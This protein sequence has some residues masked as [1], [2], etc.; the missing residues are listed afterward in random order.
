MTEFLGN[1]KGSNGTYHKISKG[2]D[3]VV[4]CDCWAW[5]KNKT[6]KHLDE[7]YH[8]TPK[9]RKQLRQVVMMFKI[10][11]RVIYKARGWTGTLTDVSEVP[12]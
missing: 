2:S 4:Y 10:G 1:I 5:K 3:G 8:Q 9:K 12:I 6:C 11:D 7:W